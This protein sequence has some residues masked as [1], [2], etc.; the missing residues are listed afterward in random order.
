MRDRNDDGYLA[1]VF[2]LFCAFV[3][4]TILA[5]GIGIGVGWAIWG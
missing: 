5:F 2:T 3:V 4:F 1:Y